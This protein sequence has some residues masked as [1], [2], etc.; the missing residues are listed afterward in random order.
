MGSMVCTTE[1][2]EL[3]FALLDAYVEAGGNCL[4]TAHV[5]SGGKSER[6]IGEWFRERDNRETIVLID[7]GAHPYWTEP[8]V[9]PECITQDIQESLERLQSDYID[10]YLLHRDDPNAPVGPIVECLNEHQAAGRICAFGGSN[11]STVRIQEA[12]DYAAAHG[13]H[14][15]VA[16]SP[17]LSL[18]SVNEPMW[19][20]CLTLDAEGRAWHATNQ[21]P[22]FPWSS[23]AS[24][25]FT[26]RFSPEDTGN[27][28]ITRVY[29][30]EGN[31][32]RLHRALELAEQKGCTANQIALAWVL[33]QSFPV[34][35]LIGPRTLEELHSSLPALDISLTDSEA[36]WL[37]L[38]S[39]HR[40]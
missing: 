9:N 17:N 33:H 23:Q 22:L 6:A 29:F 25:F 12:N 20:G 18:A 21:L 13:L 28:D 8:R 35:A 38:E 2:K 37:N 15:F 10:I 19:G 34:F 3:T 14:G 26:G 7:K 1:N 39:E 32:E 5:Y 11:W 4:D 24:G 31:W 30:N 36:R 40:N 27:K 16:S